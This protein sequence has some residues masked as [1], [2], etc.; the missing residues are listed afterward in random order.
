LR[1]DGVTILLTSHDLTDVERLADRVAIIDRGRIVALGGPDELAS[2]AVGVLRFRLSVTLTESDRQGL[3]MR[4]DEDRGAATVVEDGGSGRYRIERVTPDPA[5]IA[6]VAA[7][8]AERGMLILELRTGSATLE[9]RYLELI[10]AAGIDDEDDDEP[11]PP[12]TSG[13]GRKRGRTQ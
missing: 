1:D 11:A 10:G 13:R 7:W 12:P 2:D 9:E 6:A 4:I 5:V 8:C 3:G